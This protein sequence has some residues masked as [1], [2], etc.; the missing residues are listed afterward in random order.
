MNIRSSGAEL[1]RVDGRT[2]G[3]TDMTKPIVAFRNFT[4]APKPVSW[5]DTAN[6]PTACNRAVN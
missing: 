4:D 1:F 5:R 2:D 6:R 3:R